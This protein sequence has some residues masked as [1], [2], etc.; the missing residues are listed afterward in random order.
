MDFLALLEAAQAAQATAMTEALATLRAERGGAIAEQ[1]RPVV[2]GIGLAHELDTADFTVPGTAG[3]LEDIELF[4]PGQRF[5]PP[6]AVDW[7]GLALTVEALHWDDIEL[8]C[9]A[10]TAPD[11]ADAWFVQWFAPDTPRRGTEAAFAGVI[12]SAAFGHDPTSPVGWIT[13]VDLGSAPVA[14]MTDLLDLLAAGGAETCWLDTTH[15]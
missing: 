1:I 5:A 10:G 15:G 9:E 4:G 13:N 7:H 8:R 6:L 2:P 12:H 11:A 3:G 14:A